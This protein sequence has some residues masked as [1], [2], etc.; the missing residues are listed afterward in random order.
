MLARL[1]SRLTYANVIAT[2]ALFAALGGG[3]YAAATING[4]LL[5]NRSVA[6]I[7]LKKNTLTG[8][9]IKEATLGTVPHAAGADNAANAANAGHATS[10]DSAT[11][12][13]HAT[14][15][16]SATNAGHA[17]TADSATTA[18]GLTASENW[19]LIGAAGEPAFQHG[20]QNR[21]GAD[22]P[23]GFYKDHDGIV[24]LRGEVV[25]GST[26]NSIF[27]LPAGYRPAS[28]K[29]IVVAAACQC[30]TTV[31]VGA[32]SGTVMLPSAAVTIEG[33]GIGALD[34][35]VSV[36]TTVPIGNSL[37]LDG[38]SFRAES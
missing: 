34:G 1:R 3:A 31:V 2:I 19:H 22:S 18:S 7:K 13:G 14:S 11:S 23:A 26:N 6:G 24:H 9:E 37:W 32:N 29:G 36:S 33:S 28:G 4:K 38:I 21:G 10:A 17:S 30:Q 5:K 20:W 8:K 25:D 35:A 15:A 27:Q 16:D 12:A